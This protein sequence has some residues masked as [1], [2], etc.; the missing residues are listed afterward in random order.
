MPT[1]QE[2]P[3]STPLFG[4]RRADNLISW[5][6]FFLIT[7]YFIHYFVERTYEFLTGDYTRLSRL[8]RLNPLPGANSAD[9]S[10]DL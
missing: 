6:I 10:G 5:L 9:G 2:T 3:R 8:Y 4:S 7:Y 1:D